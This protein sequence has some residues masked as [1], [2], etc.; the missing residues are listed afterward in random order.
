MTDRLKRVNLAVR[1]VKEHAESLY[2]E[3][4]L[5]CQSSSLKFY[6]FDVMVIGRG[7]KKFTGIV[8]LVPSIP[9][10]QEMLLFQQE[11]VGELTSF[12]H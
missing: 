6:T 11:N 12:R 8:L 2:S 3:Y 9:F 5:S 1:H 7:P 10:S 4:L